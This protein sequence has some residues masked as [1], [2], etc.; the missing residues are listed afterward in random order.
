MTRKEQ[1]E[2]QYR[3]SRAAN[4][5]GT[6]GKTL[7]GGSNGGLASG[8]VKCVVIVA[9]IAAAVWAYRVFV[10]AKPAFDDEAPVEE[11]Q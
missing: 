4:G 2:Q 8:L 9:V 1:L 7:Q 3:K 10:V 11:D 6:Q 5:Y